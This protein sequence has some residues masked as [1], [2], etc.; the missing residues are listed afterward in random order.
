MLKTQTFKLNKAQWFI[1][2]FS[3]EVSQINHSIDPLHSFSQV[4]YGNWREDGL[5][6]GTQ[7]VLCFQ[8]IGILKIVMQ[9][10]RKFPIESKMRLNIVPMAENVLFNH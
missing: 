3:A 10:N 6:M 7:L 4:N 5:L 9:T 2:E 1:I 8:Y